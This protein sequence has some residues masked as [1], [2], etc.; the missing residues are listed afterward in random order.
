MLTFIKETLCNRMLGS[1]RCEDRLDNG[2]CPHNPGWVHGMPF[3]CPNKFSNSRVEEVNRI[4]E[5]GK[6]KIYFVFKT[7][8]R[9][10]TCPFKSCDDAVLQE[11]ANGDGKKLVCIFCGSEFRIV[12]GKLEKVKKKRMITL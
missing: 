4:V 11:R 1:S 5:N 7:D 2:R 12:K 6:V 9:I 8:S 10:F 3:Y